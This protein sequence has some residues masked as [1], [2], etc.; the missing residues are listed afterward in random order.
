MSHETTRLGPFKVDTLLGCDAC[1][2]S[3]MQPDTFLCK[4]CWGR[5][6]K[7]ECQEVVATIERTMVAAVKA[8]AS[9]QAWD[10]SLLLPKAKAGELTQGEANEA[11]LTIRLATPFD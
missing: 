4:T 5:L 9:R 8:G 7:K 11:M 6:H 2:D 1:G 10:I 3:D